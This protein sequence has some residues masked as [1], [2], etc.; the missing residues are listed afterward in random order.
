MYLYCKKQRSVQHTCSLR[1]AQLDVSETA[2]LHRTTGREN[3][4]TDASIIHQNVLKQ[5]NTFESRPD[6]PLSFVLISFFSL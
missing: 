6:L 4:S 5:Q 3:S 2:L 1:S